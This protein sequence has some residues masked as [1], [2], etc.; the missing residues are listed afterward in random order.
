MCLGAFCQKDKHLINIMKYKYKDTM[1]VN[2]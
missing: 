1:R 2:E